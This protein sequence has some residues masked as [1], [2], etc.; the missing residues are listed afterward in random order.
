MSAYC[1]SMIILDIKY[2]TEIRNRKE[3]D[4][5]VYIPDNIHA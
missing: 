3:L 4:H 5:S 1:Y 2:M